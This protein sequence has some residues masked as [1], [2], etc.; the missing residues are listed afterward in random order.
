[1]IRANNPHPTWVVTALVEGVRQS[2]YFTNFEAAREFA[3]QLPK[4]HLPISIYKAEL[5]AERA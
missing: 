5:V 2:R 3:N 4:H 1:M